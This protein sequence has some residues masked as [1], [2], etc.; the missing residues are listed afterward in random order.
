MKRV[1]GEEEPKISWLKIVADVLLF[2]FLERGRE[3][4]EIESK[5]RALLPDCG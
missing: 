3:E 2:N 4:K 1:R 5:N